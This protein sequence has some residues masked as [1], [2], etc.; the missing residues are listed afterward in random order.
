MSRSSRKSAARYSCPW[1]NHSEIFQYLPLLHRSAYHHV[2][3]ILRELFRARSPAGFK[4]LTR[5]PL[6]YTCLSTNDIPKVETT[7]QTLRV[8]IY[9][10]LDLLCDISADLPRRSVDQHGYLDMRTPNSSYTNT[11]HTHRYTHI[12]IEEEGWKRDTFNSYPLPYISRNPQAA[13]TTALSEIVTVRQE[14]TPQ[15]SLC[16]L[17]K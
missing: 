16:M 5:K 9:P 6:V 10:I 2:S 12:P 17:L 8:Y 7:S 15:G 11:K 1:I 3:V 4:A 13:Q 14:A